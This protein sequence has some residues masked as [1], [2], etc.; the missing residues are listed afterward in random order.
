[1]KID[2]ASNHFR[3]IPQ[4]LPCL[5]PNLSTLNVSNNSISELNCLAVFPAS[6]SSLDFSHN[7]LQHFRPFG[8]LSTLVN[9][10]CYSSVEGD[11]PSLRRRV[12]DNKGV[13]S[14]GNRLR[15]CR[16]S[17]HKILPH[18]KRLDLSRNQIKEICLIIPHRDRVSS[19]SPETRNSRKG[20]GSAW[21]TEKEVVKRTKADHVLF[22]SLQTLYLS[23]NPISALPKDIG[24]QSKLGALHLNHTEVSQLPPELGLLSDLWDLQ[25][26]GLQLQDID[27]SVLERKRTKDVVGYLRSILEK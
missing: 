9:K 6:L 19:D 5:A 18:L 22:P 12:S 4:G 24:M 15:F 8:D 1:M 17:R 10:T 26:H 16:H 7:Q 11:R 20:K 23:N 27:S 2:L 13:P 21:L 3:S 14:A 25:Y